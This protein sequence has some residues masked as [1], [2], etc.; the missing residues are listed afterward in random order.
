MLLPL[1]QL[2][3]CWFWDTDGVKQEGGGDGGLVRRRAGE[4]ICAKIIN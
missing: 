4:E 2:Q 1:L 3:N